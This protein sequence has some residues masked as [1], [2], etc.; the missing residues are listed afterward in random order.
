MKNYI[1]NFLYDIFVLF[2]LSYVTY[3]KKELISISDIYLFFLDLAVR[4]GE[5]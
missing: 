5:I 4:Y 2:L 3:T 1:I